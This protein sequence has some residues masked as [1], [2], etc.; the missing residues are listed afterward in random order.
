M[1][2]SIIWCSRSSAAN[3]SGY[4]QIQLEEQDESAL[5]GKENSDYDHY[6]NNV[7]SYESVNDYRN[8]RNEESKAINPAIN[9]D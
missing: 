9:D 4:S 7:I 3:K 2:D 8:S 6:N 1:P 5:L